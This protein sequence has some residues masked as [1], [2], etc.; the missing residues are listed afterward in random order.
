METKNLLKLKQY[1]REQG[2]TQ[3]KAAAR[4]GQTAMAVNILLNGK[5]NFGVK[6]AMDWSREFGLNPMWLMTGEGDMLMD[7]PSIPDNVVLV[8]HLNLDARQGFAYNE[9]MDVQQYTIDMIPFSASVA[10]DGDFMVSVYGD[11]MSPRF[12]NGSLVLARPIPSWREY[13]EMG[14][15]YIIELQDGRRLVKIVRQ[16]SDNEHLLL[17]SVNPAYEPSEVARDFVARMY[18]VI[19]CARKEAM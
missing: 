16:G 5:R 14:A 6:S 7:K 1:F 9:E 10:R 8:P 4:L 3:E 19:L 18:L 13:L 12:P 11:S 17:C 2:L 15:T